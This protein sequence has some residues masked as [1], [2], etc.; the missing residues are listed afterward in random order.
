MIYFDNAATSL[1]KPKKVIAEAVNSMKNHGNPGRGGYPLSMSA[2]QT[3]FN[4]RLA[5]ANF[6][7]NHAPERVIFTQNATISLNI[8]IKCFA[9]EG[10]NESSRILISCFEHNSVYRTVY[11]FPHDIFDVSLSDDEATVENAAKLVS[12]NTQMLVITHVSNVCGKILPIREIIKQAKEK[13]PNIIAVVDAAQSAGVLDIDMNRDNIDILCVPAHKSMLGITGLGVLLLHEKLEI[14]KKT[15]IVGGTGANSLDPFMPVDPPERFEAGT[16]NTPAIAALGAAVEY[17]NAES[18]SKIYA[19]EKNLY[20]TAVD[21]LSEMGNIKL[22][23]DFS[24]SEYIGAILFNTRLKCE[25]TSKILARNNI[26]MRDGYH[27][28][29]LAHKKL[30]TIDTGGVRISF[31]YRNNIKELEKLCKVLKN[32]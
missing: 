11:G 5:L 27:C 6:F 25:D 21:M 31:G 28:S 20:D 1:H 2:A 30:C 16:P 19:H 3:I 15:F 12:E 32:I 9:N 7:K 18:I 8:A 23:G 29:P 24:N 4:T 22:Y 26:F 17:I 10:E 14:P 13:N